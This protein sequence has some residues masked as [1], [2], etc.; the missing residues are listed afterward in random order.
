MTNPSPT[1]RRSSFSADTGNCVEVAPVDDTVLVRNSNRTA[2]GALPLS[3]NAATT[4]ITA[5]RDGR[6]DHLV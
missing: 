1:W 5:A 3:T 6:F 4:F 2:D